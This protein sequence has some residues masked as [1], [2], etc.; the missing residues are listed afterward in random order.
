ET[1]L[2]TLL[3]SPTWLRSSSSRNTASGVAVMRL[4]EQSHS[5]D[6]AQPVRNSVYAC[7]FISSLKGPM[8]TKSSTAIS[9][10]SGPQLSTENPGS[11]AAFTRRLV[12]WLYSSTARDRPVV[13]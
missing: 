1:E 7:H 9:S 13:S 11:F 2:T 3:K 6:I 4:N 5:E 12:V 8:R 10:A